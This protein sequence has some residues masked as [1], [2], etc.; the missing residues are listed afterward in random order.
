MKRFVP[1]NENR[2]PSEE[3]VEII[4]HAKELAWFLP[5]NKMNSS[6]SLNP[7]KR[8]SKGSMTQVETQTIY[9]MDL[10]NKVCG[11]IQIL[12][13]NVMNGVYKGFQL[14]LKIFTPIPNDPR[15]KELDIWESIKLDNVKFDNDY[16]SVKGSK[17]EYEIRSYTTMKQSQFNM[18]L[19]SISMNSSKLQMQL[20]VQLGEGFRITPNGC[21]FYLDKRTYPNEIDYPNLGKKLKRYMRH[22]FVPIGKCEGSINYSIADKKNTS[23]K[24]NTGTNSLLL[25]E[26]PILYI[27]AVQG[28]LPNKAA[29][30]WNFLY[31]Q[32]KSYSVQI[33]EYLTT[34]RYDNVKVTIWSITKDDKTISKNSEINNDNIVQFINTKIDPENEFSIPTTVKFKFSETDEI[35]IDELNLVNRYDIL[36]EFPHIVKKLAEDIVNIKPY[37]YQYCQETEF[38]GEKGISI[39]ETSFVSL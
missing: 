8:D 33:M 28:L 17:F 14:N 9:F 36:G 39:Y 29:K 27:D 6:K 19:I 31:F 4:K 1:L 35:N 2:G 18:G 38:N 22:Q 3:N 30:R 24:L 26:V 15:N 7:F 34:E 13:S 23:N 37:L 32:S 5:S 12:Y 21:S 20:K 10:E 25:Q 11:F 16:L